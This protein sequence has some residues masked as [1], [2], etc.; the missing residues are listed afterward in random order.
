[1]K[2]YFCFI[3]TIIHYQSNPSILHLDYEDP[4]ENSKELQLVVDY[5]DFILPYRCD[6]GK[7]FIHHY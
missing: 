6:V 3:Q 5:N 2:V 1:M 7:L 4:V